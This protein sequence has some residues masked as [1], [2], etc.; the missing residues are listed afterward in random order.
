MALEIAGVVLE[1]LIHIEAHEAARFVR[2]AIPGMNGELSQE[3]GRPCV[4]MSVQGIFYG[5]EAFSQLEILRGNLLDRT[6][7]DFVCEMTGSGYVAQVVVDRFDVAQRAGH[8]DEFEYTCIVT[9]YVPPPPPPTSSLMQDLDLSVLEEATA[10]LDDIQDA[11][12][13]VESLTDLLS[14]AEDFGNPVTRLPG[15]L[16]AFSS[17]AGGASGTTTSIEEQL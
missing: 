16:D 13:V 15:L 8:P 2:H 5:S 6:P 3:M 7:V 9:E 10:M 11:L 4:Q 12:A 17:V 1:K 14:G